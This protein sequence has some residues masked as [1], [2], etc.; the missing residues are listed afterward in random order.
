VKDQTA[1][2][3]RTPGCRHDEA[4]DVRDRHHL[5]AGETAR[6]ARSQESAGDRRE[7]P[8]G[9]PA[10]PD[11][12]ATGRRTF[13]SSWWKGC[14]VW[15]RASASVGGTSR[16][17][18]Q[19]LVE[20]DGLFLCTL[21]SS[22]VGAVETSESGK[23]GAARGFEPFSRIL[24][25]FSRIYHQ[26]QQP[27]PRSRGGG[28]GRPHVGHRSQKIKL[29][30]CDAASTDPCCSATR[31]KRRAWISPQRGECEKISFEDAQH[32]GPVENF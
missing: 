23:L 19:I 20:R 17:S 2:S 12:G 8:S 21:T 16:P 9:R 24:Q 6:D 32:I 14:I 26:L 1:I 27:Q 15:R 13:R 18:A 4:R 10:K 3:R 31:T 7:H 29:S 11:P 28:S 22:V 30:K 5:R 25:V